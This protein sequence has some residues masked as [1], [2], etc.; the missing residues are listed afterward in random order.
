VSIARPE[1]LALAIL[2]LPEL[3]L[4]LR[5]MPAFRDSVGT[6]A[7]PRGRARAERRFA[8]FS[9]ASTAAAALFVVA[10][11]CALSGPSWGLRG[12]AVERRGLEAAIVLDVSRSME[13]RDMGRGAASRLGAAKTLIAELSAG[14]GGE[15]AR[16]SPGAAA[17]SLVAAK[18][19]A[20][21]LLPM[22]E[23]RFALEDA[24][25]YANPDAISSP[26]TNLESGLRAAFASF[27]SSGA[28]GR[29]VFLFTDGGEL[30]GSARRACSEAA[31]VRARLVVVGLGGAVPVPVPGP[32][33]APLLG[34]KGPVLS[35][36]E[37]RSLEDL[38]AAAGGRYVDASEPGAEA[39]LADELSAASGTGARI[40][41]RAVDRS[42]LFASV[43]LVFFLIALLASMLATGRIKA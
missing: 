18:G 23:D 13:A 33:G 9:V 10:A 43:A 20:V 31:A 34:D 5:R 38:A 3:A 16:A 42:P 39:A 7:G 32:D 35:R 41:Y 6:L 14:A 24:L 30:S 17:F 1:L 28:Q 4:G 29:V 36:L 12:A 8:F 27:S 26:G 37:S 22:T 40:E 25:A 15:G 19:G 2:A 21:L 11:A